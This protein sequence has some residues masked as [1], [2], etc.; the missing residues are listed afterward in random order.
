MFLKKLV[1]SVLQARCL[2][3]KLADNFLLWNRGLI[4]AVYK[5]LRCF[6]EIDFEEDEEVL[7]FFITS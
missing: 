7:Y 1:D 3:Q 2:G 5:M 4:K 6:G